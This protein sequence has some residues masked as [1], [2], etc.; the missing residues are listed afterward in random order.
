MLVPGTCANQGRPNN[1]SLDTRHFYC[2]RL[3]R[4]VPQCLYCRPL[5]TDSQAVHI[6]LSPWPLTLKNV[7][8]DGSCLYRA[9]SVVLFGA[10]EHHIHI[11]RRIVAFMAHHADFFR[12]T[13][14]AMNPDLPGRPHL[15]ELEDYLVYMKLPSEFS[16]Y[17]S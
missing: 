3:K 13:H 8:A 17:V 2:P 1:R 11:R 5:P 6:E 7:S 16:F 14:L 10:P 9:L 15:P 12:A 4:L